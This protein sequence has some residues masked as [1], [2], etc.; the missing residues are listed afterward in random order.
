MD[1]VFGC[2]AHGNS[3]ERLEPP[4]SAIWFHSHGRIWVPFPDEDNNAL[5]EAWHRVKDELVQRARAR[6]TD[7]QQRSPRSWLTT[8]LWGESAYNTDSV[9]PPRPPRPMPSEKQTEPTYRI[10]DPDEPA[11]QRRFRVPVLEDRLF[12]VDMEHMIVRTVQVISTDTQMYPALWAGYDQQVIRATWFYV[13]SDGACS[14]IACNTRLE[15]DIVNAYR[16]AEPW[17]LEHRLKGTLSKSRREDQAVQYDLPSVVSGAKIQFI[18]AYSA[19]VYAQ[20]IGSK[21]FPFLREP[22]LVRGFENARELS[23]R[24]GS[25]TRLSTWTR[26]PESTSPRRT[27]AASTA[28]SAEDVRDK[29]TIERFGPISEEDSNATGIIGD[30]ATPDPSV[31]PSLWVPL[32]EAFMSR[33]WVSRSPSTNPRVR[34]IIEDARPQDPFDDDCSM[35]S[36]S[37]QP[38]QLLFCIHGIGQKLSEDYASMHFVHDLD[39]LRTIMRA[40]AQ[41][42]ELKPLL[43]GGRVKLIPICWR[44]NLQFDPEQESYTLQD[45]VNATSIPSVRTVVT[46]V[47][48]DIPFYFSRHHDLMERSVLHEMNRLYRLFVQRNPGF[49]QNGGR[50]SIL[51]HSLGSMLAADILKDQ[52]TFVRPLHETDAPNIHMLS[53]HLLFNVRH[54]FCIGSPLP[55]LY[56]MNGAR[57]IARRR[58]DDDV[59]DATSAEVGKM[60]CLASESVYNVSSAPILPEVTNSFQLYIATDPISFQMSALADAPYSRIVRP[61][62]LPRDPSLLMDA[63]EEPRVNVGKLLMRVVNEKQ[64]PTTSGT[65]DQNTVPSTPRSRP[66]P[67]EDMERGE[68]R[69][70]AL[71]PN[72][73]IDYIMDVGTSSSVCVRVHQSMV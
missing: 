29:D 18:S 70:N 27:P 73:C 10:T 3:T 9:L 51:G 41:D 48:L 42:I 5:E 65:Q 61:V 20:N 12:D 59:D 63:L 43:N 36:T 24:L 23:E 8:S 19:R 2:P 11:E 46:K 7:N 28:A 62:H 52:P 44:R 64:V 21:L 47:L 1:A 35:P 14:P 26:R 67:L 53:P 39:R 6:H 45:I 33:A 31:S 15:E 56:Y 71:N 40:Q 58:Y 66:I 60:G 68:Q 30:R 72:G 69:F 25:S 16:T 49:E 37:D 13:A 34:D 22:T 57:L 55:L 54:F 38:P 50:V 32:N 4:V 17:R